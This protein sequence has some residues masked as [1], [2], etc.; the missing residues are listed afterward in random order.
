MSEVTKED[1]NR[2]YDKMGEVGKEV[3]E[4]NVCVAVIDTKLELHLNSHDKW[5]RPIIRL[6]F[7]FVKMGIVCIITWV[8]VRKS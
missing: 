8:F 5:G 7:D 3:T 6:A 1:I 4:T 2:L